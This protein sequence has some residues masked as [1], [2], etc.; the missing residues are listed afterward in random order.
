MPDCM[1]KLKPINSKKLKPIN[2]N[3]AQVVSI[4]LKPLCK[5]SIFSHEIS[6]FPYLEEDEDNVSLM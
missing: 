6:T 5:M 3:T 1:V 2:Y 4:Y